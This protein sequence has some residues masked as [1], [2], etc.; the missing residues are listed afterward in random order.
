[1]AG[2]NRLNP[3]TFGASSDLF[4]IQRSNCF[5]L[6]FTCSSCSCAGFHAGTDVPGLVPGKFPHYLESGPP[7]VSE[8]PGKG[9]E[10]RLNMKAN[11]TC[12]TRPIIVN[13]HS[14]R[15]LGQTPDS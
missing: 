13:A 1:M 4:L 14:H 3:L 9:A 6:S 5:L 10:E 7:E 2:R 15:W 8:K 11:L 12:Y